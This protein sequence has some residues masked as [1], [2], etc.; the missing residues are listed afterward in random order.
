VLF[1]AGYVICGT[2][3]GYVICGASRGYVIQ[4]VEGCG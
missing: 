2:T 1:S 3:E 4:G